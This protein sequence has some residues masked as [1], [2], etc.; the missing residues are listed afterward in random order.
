ME[1]SSD[2]EEALGQYR[3]VMFAQSVFEYDDEALSDKVCDMLRLWNG[4]RKPR[5]VDITLT[6]RCE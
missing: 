4:E 3:S 1:S 6:R 2:S 5:G